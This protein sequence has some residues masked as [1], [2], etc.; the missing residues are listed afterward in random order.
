MKRELKREL[1]KS[2]QNG[3]WDKEVLTPEQIRYAAM[4]AH[5]R[6]RGGQ[7]KLPRI[8]LPRRS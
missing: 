3:E 7:G 6:A 2:E 8:R 4:D 5:M 1:D